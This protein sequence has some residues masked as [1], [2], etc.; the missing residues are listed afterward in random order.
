MST[1][2]SRIRT[3]SL[4]TVHWIGIALAAIS[5]AI[6]LLLGVS[7]APEPMG[8]AFLLAGVGFFGAIALVL[9]DYRRRLVYAIGI[10]FTGVQIPLWYVANYDSLAEITTAG[11]I[12]IVD[13]LAQMALLVV[14]LVLL[15]KTE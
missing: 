6:H 12:E 11:P 10:P 5:G 2:R 9:V 15:S 1:Q 7:F 4:G 14:L 3:H 13:K 8:I